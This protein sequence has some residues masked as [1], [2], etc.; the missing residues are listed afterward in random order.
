MMKQAPAS[1]END[2]AVL[3]VEELLKR[4]LVPVWLRPESAL[5]YAHEAFLVRDYLDLPLRSPSLEL[6]CMDGTATFVMLGGEFELPFD[7]YREDSPHS[8]IK[9][10]P[11]SRFDAGIAWKKEHLQ[12]AR[13][14]G[15][16][17][18][19][20]DHDLNQPLAML[21]SDQFAVI[22]GPN[23]Y[24]I[25]QLE[26]LLREVHRVLRPG[27]K[28]VTV[29]PDSAALEYMLYRFKQRTDIAWIQD[30]DR[31]RHENVSRQARKLEDWKRLFEQT[32]FSLKRHQ[33]FIS[34][35]ILQVH[36]IGLRPLFPVLT[37]TYKILQKKSPEDF[38]RIKQAWIDTAYH[39]LSPLCRTDWMEEMKFPTV[40]HIFELGT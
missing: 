11:V 8:F 22:W 14:L 29:L 6:G 25:D 21:K 12:K 23:L 38:L 13:K 37:D 3:S 31:G 28:F 34:K 16:Y 27:G 17:L 26:A 15:T 35:L 20:I 1:K 39:F 5:W 19:L 9:T 4:L 30:L 24:W 32:G 2:L 7:V 33:P 36:D 10:A 40:W 18:R